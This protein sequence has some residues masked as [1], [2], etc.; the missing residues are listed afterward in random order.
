MAGYTYDPS[1]S[2][3]QGFQQATASIG[4]IFNQV[5]QQQHRDYTLA[6]NTFQNIEALKKDL[7]IFGQKNVTQKSND[8]LKE[9][10][11]AILSSGKLDYSKLG[12]IRQK[13]SDIKDLKQGYELGAKE[14]ERMLQLGI[15]NKD[16][17]VS[18][19]KFYKDLS[20]KMGD[21]NLV[22]NP[23]D[24]QRAMADTYSNNLDSFKIFGKSYLSS[25]PYQK[26]S[27]DIKDP[28][29]G[30]LMR[31]QGELPAGWTLDAQGNKIPPPPQTIKDPNTG[32][33]ITMDYVDQELARLKSTNPEALMLMRKQ[34]GFAAENL[35]DKDLV[36]A[37]IDRIP[38]TIQATQVASKSKIDMEEAQAKS[39]QFETE[40][41]GEKLSAQLGQIRASTRASNASAALHEK[42]MDMYNKPQ[43]LDD[44]KS[45]GIQFNNNGARLNLGGAVAFDLVKPDGTTMKVGASEIYS[46][47]GK[48]Y[49]KYYV[50]NASK[51]IDEQ[52]RSGFQGS[53]AKEIPLQDNFAQSQTYTNLQNALM[54]AKSGKKAILSNALK[55]LPSAI[56]GYKPTTP[57]AATE[58]V[59]KYGTYKGFDLDVLAAA[60]KGASVEQLKS[61]IDNQ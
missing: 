47:N 45:L 54:G 9:A 5:I 17:L 20:A 44:Y 55:Y 38:M 37:S 23:Q 19:E 21:E 46:K 25:N 56:D 4:G 59:K 2:I 11:A 14:Y 57:T 27:Q 3:K 39:A 58:P 24:L 12:E 35:T 53:T 8:L 22:K 42:Q 18:F 15:A 10:G 40:H 16:N 31:V 6:E 26:I 41:Q 36:K 30:S 51:D 1:E 49:L 34:A 13:V 33:V 48:K 61:A 50:P 43:S 7:N 28:K 29:T 60:N 52:I 32:A